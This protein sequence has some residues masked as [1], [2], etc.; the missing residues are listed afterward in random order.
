MKTYPIFIRIEDK[1]CLVVGGGAVGERKVLDL[2]EAGAR[3]TLL[4]QTL[5]PTLTELAQT[6]EIRYL[7]EAF[8]LDHLNGMV[9]AMAA[10]DDR[11]VNARVSAAA[12]ARG[13]WVNVADDPEYCTFIVPAQVRQGDLTLA[14]STGGASPAVAQKLRQELEQRFGPEYKPYLA[15]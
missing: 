11:E 15:L 1:P 14:I 3:V 13:I 5:T 12:Q 6:G 9:L 2:R 7:N 4:S 10:T 8:T